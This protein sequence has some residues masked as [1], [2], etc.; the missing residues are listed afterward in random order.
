MIFSLISFLLLGL[1]AGAIARLLVPGRDRLGL[2]M[3]AA[4]GM[5]GSFVGGFL[6]YLIGHDRAAGGVHASGLFGS[7]VG[8]IVVLLIYRRVGHKRLARR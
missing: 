5:V 4:L 3:T 8:A 1:I 7:I 2:L 6:G